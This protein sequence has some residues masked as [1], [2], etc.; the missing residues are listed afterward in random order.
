[1]A[2]KYWDQ[3]LFLS[4]IKQNVERRGNKDSFEIFPDPAFFRKNSKNNKDENINI[5]KIWFYLN[6]IDRSKEIRRN[7]LCK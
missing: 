5:L 2:F 1:M 3:E 4:H 6:K 7:I